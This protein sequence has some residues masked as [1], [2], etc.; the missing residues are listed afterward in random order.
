MVLSKGEGERVGITDLLVGVTDE[1][2]RSWGLRA[3]ILRYELK[4]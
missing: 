2:I 1:A 4:L 3:R